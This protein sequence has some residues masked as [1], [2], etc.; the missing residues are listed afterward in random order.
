MNDTGSELFLLFFFFFF[1]VCNTTTH[2]FPKH[3][4][5]LVWYR[6]S[7][8]YMYHDSVGGSLLPEARALMK[9]TASYVLPGSDDYQFKIAPTPQQANDFDCGITSTPF[10]YYCSLIESCIHLFCGIAMF[11]N[12]FVCDEVD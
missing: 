11:N 8:T 5:L 2:P 9:Q 1:F 4:G 6:R 12:R 7:K 10:Y 3:R